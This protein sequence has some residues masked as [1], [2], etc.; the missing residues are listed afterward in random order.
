MTTSVATPIPNESMP[1]VLIVPR[2]WR[3]F[4]RKLCGRMRRWYCSMRKVDTHP[5]MVYTDC[6]GEVVRNK[7]CN[8]TITT[9]KSLPQPLRGS[10][11]PDVSVR[12]LLHK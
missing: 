12:I 7:K 8:C 2:S 9:H 4:R 1:T 11:A 10:G 5:C 3:L 6:G